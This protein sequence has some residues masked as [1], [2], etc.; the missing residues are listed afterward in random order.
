MR[1]DLVALARH[2]I[3]LGIPAHVIVNNRAEGCAPE[4]IR[5]VGEMLVE[6]IDD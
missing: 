6:G 5:A 1:N 3:R 2:A 4:T